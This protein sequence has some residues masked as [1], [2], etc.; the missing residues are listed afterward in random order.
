MRMFVPRRMRRRDAGD[1]RQHGERLEP[2]A[3]G[4]GGLLTTGGPAD[5]G[6]RVL[7]EV[8]TEHHVVGHDEPIEAGGLGR[9][10]AVQH[11]LPPTGILRAVGRE[12]E[13]ELREPA[14]G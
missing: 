2:I 5:L 9:T 7:L 14:A 8:L 11:V 6:S 1:D 13:R 12:V 10:C 4:S 3:V